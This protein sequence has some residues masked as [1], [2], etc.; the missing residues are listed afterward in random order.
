MGSEVSNFCFTLFFFCNVYINSELLRFTKYHYKPT[1][2]TYLYLWPQDKPPNWK[3]SNAMKI[4]I[5]NILMGRNLFLYFSCVKLRRKGKF[6]YLLILILLSL[7]FQCW[8]ISSNIHSVKRHIIKLIDFKT[9]LHINNCNINAESK[10]AAR[11]IIAVIRAKYSFVDRQIFSKSWI[12]CSKGM[13]S[14]SSSKSL[15][16]IN[17]CNSILKN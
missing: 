5:W 11:V 8:Q 14:L 3:Q 17:T 12:L 2:P 16:E 1:F 13:F 6:V 15:L 4:I 9:Y 10:T 7:L